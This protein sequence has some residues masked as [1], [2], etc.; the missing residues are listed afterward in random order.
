[1]AAYLTPVVKQ[2]L[3][4]GV[5]NSRLSPFPKLSATGVIFGGMA[6]V[7]AVTAMVFAL[8]TEYLWLRALYAP[9]LAA[10]VTAGTAVFLSLVAAWISSIAMKRG[11]E[12]NALSRGPSPDIAKTLSSLIDSFGDELEQ[13]IREN[14]KT[15]VMLASLAGFMAGDRSHH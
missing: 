3:I 7:L 10:L 12:R 6:S 1:M 14:P 2:L 13:P 8:M 5:L 15:A 9:Y 11:R 4:D